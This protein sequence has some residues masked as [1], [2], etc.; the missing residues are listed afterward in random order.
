M[1]TNLIFILTI[2]LL[3]LQVEVQAV[4][5]GTL[6]KNTRSQMMREQT[7]KFTILLWNP[8]NSSFPVKLRAIQV[9]EGLSIIISPKEFIMNSSMLDGH[10]AE[11][12]NEYV[13]TPYGLM[14]TT[15][16]DVLVKTSKSINSGEYNFYVNL[17]AGNPTTGISPIF[18]KT[19]KFDVKVVDYIITKQAATTVQKT[20]KETSQS[21]NETVKEKITGMFSKLSNNTYLIFIVSLMIG[22]FL[23]AWTIY[24]H[25]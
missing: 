14:K 17:A 23:V 8:E 15:P 7:I 3:F 18:D 4:G 16:V 21:V 10:S 6:V 22:I 1:K 2:F 12:E 24:K 19:I 13:N 20:K 25:E 11:S 9:P 5:L